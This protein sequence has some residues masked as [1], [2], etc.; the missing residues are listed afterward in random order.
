ML[1]KQQQLYPIVSHGGRLCFEEGHVARRSK[2]P[3]PIQMATEET[4][5]L[6]TENGRK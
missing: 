5:E 4:E 1:R 3:M 6:Q 2:Q